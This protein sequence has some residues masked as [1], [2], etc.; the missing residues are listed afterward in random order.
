M[1]PDPRKDAAKLGH[2]VP[3]GFC[4]VCNKPTRKGQ[5]FMC[6]PHWASIPWDLGRRLNSARQN[7]KTM[8]DQDGAY[9]RL[10]QEAIGLLKQK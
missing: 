1:L 10:M 7:H 9:Y 4:H 6:W 2:I 5:F 8:W 3:T